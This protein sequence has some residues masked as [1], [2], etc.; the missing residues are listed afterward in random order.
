MTSRS[1]AVVPTAAR[2]G[3]LPLPAAV[4]AWVKTMRRQAP[5]QDAD[6]GLA[7][8]AAADPALGA[9]VTVLAATLTGRDDPARRFRF[10]S[11]LPG[12]LDDD[13]LRDLAALSASP[14]VCV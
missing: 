9:G 3:V 5:A 10:E 6:F 11:S 8:R 7:V 14:N 1:A 12:V 13:T 2:A 4:R